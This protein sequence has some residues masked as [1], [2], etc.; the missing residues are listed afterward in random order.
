MNV[1][2]CGMIGSGKTTIGERV[3]GDLGLGFLDLDRE[4][5]NRLGYSFHRLVAEKGWLAFRE[6]EYSICKYFAARSDAIIC[7]GGGT[8]RYG[9]NTDLLKPTG[10]FILFEAS[11]ECLIGRVMQAD[12]PRVNT[13][14]SLEE[15]IRLMWENEKYKYYA[16][17]D[18]VYRTDEKPIDTEI[19][20]IDELL[21]S[22]SRFSG[23]RFG[24]GADS[25]IASLRPQDP[26]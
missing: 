4:M 2:L 6:L 10:P 13:G 12:R 24:S 16:A 5:D 9:W 25:G 21:F 8:V 23:L 18:I 1:Y 26:N 15:D 3:A 17:A 19:R 20:E 11:V 14:A 22:D 7:L